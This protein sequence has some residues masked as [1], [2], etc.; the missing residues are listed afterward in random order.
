MKIRFMALALVAGAAVSSANAQTLLSYW[1][2]NDSTPG[3]AGSLGILNAG[4][5]N[6]NA[7]VFAGT[8]TLG[9][10]LVANSNATTSNGAVGTFAG[11]VLSALP[12]DVA[13]NPGGALSI[14]GNASGSGTNISSNGGF[15]VFN[16][17]SLGYN[18]LNLKFDGRGT[19]TGFSNNKIETSTDGVTW[20]TQVASYSSTATTFSTFNYALTAAAD[21]ASS[22]KVRITFNGATS[23]AGNNRIDNFQISGTA[24]PTPGSLALLGL[25]GLVAGRRRR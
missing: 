16:L 8:L 23:G 11:A 17:S 24:I 20:V 15:I 3:V 7:G 13:N 1:N 25:G 6:S 9:G 21:N 4:G 18:T 10:G 19:G 12:A 5:F 2:F 14:R 22:L